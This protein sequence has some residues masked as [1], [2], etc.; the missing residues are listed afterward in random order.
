MYEKLGDLLKDAL[1][2]PTPRHSE[3]NEESRN[4]TPPRHEQP[5]EETRNS[6]SPRHDQNIVESTT[7]TSNRHSES[8]E[9]SRNTHRVKFL[10][11]HNKLPTGQVIKEKD[12]K[13]TPKVPQEVINALFT[14]QV[15]APVTWPKIKSQYR[16][17]LKETHPDTGTQQQNISIDKIKEAFEVIKKFYGK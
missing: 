12:Y 8:N 14:L 1:E 2:N 11:L 16:K 10:F 17:L 13:E 3:F 7:Y 4:T 9:E 15:T 5:S 6:N